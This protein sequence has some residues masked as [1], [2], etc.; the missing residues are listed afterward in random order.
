MI[1]S[2]PSPTNRI[3]KKV[4]KKTREGI[5]VD[6]R[7]LYISVRRKVSGGVVAESAG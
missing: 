5:S 7:F 4:S 3:E 1:I 2:L 6:E